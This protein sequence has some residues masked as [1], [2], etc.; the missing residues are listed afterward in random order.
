MLKLI[1]HYMLQQHQQ[2][3]QRLIQLHLQQRVHKVHG[4]I[5]VEQVTATHQQIQEIHIINL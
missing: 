1:K 4:N 3:I 5:M 2:H